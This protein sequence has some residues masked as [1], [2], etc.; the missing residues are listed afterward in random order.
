MYYKLYLDSVFILQMTGNLCLLSLTGKILGCT[1]THR[2]ILL[3]ATAGA[4]MVCMVILIPAGTVGARILVSTVPVSMCMLCITFRF[5]RGRS[6]LHG[7]LIMAGC[8]FFSG[9]IMIWI[10]NRLRTVLN[11][12]GS[13]IVILVSGCLAY[14][15]LARIIDRFRRRRVSCQ[16][17]VSI[18]VPDLQRSI[19]VKAFID[20]GNQLTD[21]VSGAPVCVIGRRLAAQ[22]HSC[23]RPEKYHAIPFRSVGKESG[24]L[25]AYELPELVIEEQGRKIRKE[26]VILAI[27]DE[28]ISEESVCQMILHPR[29]LED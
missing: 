3:G 29:L 9:S 13:M 28:G 7:S 11:I 24:I 8:G 2:R 27:C 16:R 20:T 17:T 15:I 21:P 22:I 14:I 4:L 18:Y 1:A 25:H 12:G 26:H 5:C 23:F 6:L 10:L 19:P